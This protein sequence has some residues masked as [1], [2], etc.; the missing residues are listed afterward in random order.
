[1]NNINLNSGSYDSYDYLNR[2]KINPYI[3]GIVVIIIIVYYLV[4]SSLGNNG[5]PSLSSSSTSSNA[6]LAILET[7][8]WGV[9]IILLLLNGMSYIFNINIIANL[10]NVF[11]NLQ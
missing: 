9:F 10:K 2:L 7:I 11:L 6:G 8:L 1:M 5:T 3:I 4:F